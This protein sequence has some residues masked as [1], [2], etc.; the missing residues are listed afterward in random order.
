MKNSSILTLGRFIE[1]L[2]NPDYKTHEKESII[3][4][5]GYN[6]AETKSGGLIPDVYRQIPDEC[7]KYFKETM[8]SLGYPC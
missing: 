6:I 7:K 1:D 4:T 5:I 8:T 3:R 2:H